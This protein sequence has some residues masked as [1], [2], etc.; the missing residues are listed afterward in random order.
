MLFD[1][2]YNDVVGV[3]RIHHPVDNDFYLYSERVGCEITYRVVYVYF[4]R[5][6]PLC[7]DKDVVIRVICVATSQAIGNGHYVLD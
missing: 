4:F 1:I 5:L 6:F 7:D 3:Y 2:H